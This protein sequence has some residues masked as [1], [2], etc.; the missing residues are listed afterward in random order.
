MK[1]F[2]PLFALPLLWLALAQPSLAQ[3]EP[4][5]IRALSQRAL[6]GE[7][8]AQLDLGSAYDNGRGVARDLLEA[9][10]W[11]RLAAAQGLAQ[12]QY[13]LAVIY[14]FGEGMPRDYSR[15]IGWY[16]LAAKQGHRDAQF[17]LAIFYEDGLGVPQDYAAAHEWYLK[18]AEGGLSDARF[19]LGNMYIAGTGVLRDNV[20]AYKWI[21]LGAGNEEVG[22]RA[23]LDILEQMMSPAEI[24]EAKRLAAEWLMA[25]Q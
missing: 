18:A 13:N 14:T 15:A 24:A 25:H 17:N 20:Q 11:Y 19:N 4:P 7:A 3:S 1:R 6:G 2:S 22:Q 16:L 21:W 5:G 12:A 23:V 8:E 10:K 9:V